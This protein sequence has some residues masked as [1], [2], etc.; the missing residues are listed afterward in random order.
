MRNLSKSDF[1]RSEW[2]T[3]VTQVACRLATG[4]DGEHAVRWSMEEV[5]ESRWADDPDTDRFD[6]TLADVDEYLLEGHQN[7]I[8][9]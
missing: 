7:V 3:V 9:G 5:Y 1:T 8:D 6:C 4:M 2:R